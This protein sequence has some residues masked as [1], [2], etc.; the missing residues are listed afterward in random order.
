MGESLRLDA[1][2]LLKRQRSVAVRLKAQERSNLIEDT[3]ETRGGGEGF[4]NS[5]SAPGL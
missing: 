4:G 3:A 2:P 5:T 1:P